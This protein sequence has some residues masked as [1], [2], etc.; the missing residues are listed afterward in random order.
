MDEDH[1]V[2]RLSERG[3]EWEKK[4]RQRPGDPSSVLLLM[5]G[6][7]SRSDGKI[8]SIYSFLNCAAV[9]PLCLFF[10]LWLGFVAGPRPRTVT[11]VTPHW[12]APG[13]TAER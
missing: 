12:P 4:T 7:N 5:V 13:A 6:A 9:T 8:R 10:G 3:G 1:C 2:R 11:A